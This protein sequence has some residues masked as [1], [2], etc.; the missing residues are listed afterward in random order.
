MSETNNNSVIA[1]QPL[2]V[3][4]VSQLKNY[5]SYDGLNYFWNQKLI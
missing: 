4:K 5:L 1:Q 3:R 2:Q